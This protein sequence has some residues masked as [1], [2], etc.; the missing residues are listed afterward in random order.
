MLNLKPRLTAIDCTFI[1]T[2]STS[3]SDPVLLKEASNNRLKYHLHH[4]SKKYNRPRQKNGSRFYSGESIIQELNKQNITLL[5]FTIDKYG[6][7]GPLATA[8]FLDGDNVSTI[9]DP[10]TLSKFTKPALFSYQKALKNIKMRALFKLSNIGWKLV[11]K[12][13]WFGSTYQLTTPSKWGRHYLAMN[14]NIAIVQHIKKSFTIIG[15][16]KI[17]KAEKKIQNTR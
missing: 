11:N 14:L 9:T 3:M 7:L 6:S 8:Y 2:L 5:A 13:K 16:S 1:S 17:V 12:D 10:T 4:E 15:K